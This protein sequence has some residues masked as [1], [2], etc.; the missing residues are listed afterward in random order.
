[1]ARTA[2][3][4]SAGLTG[5]RK[6]PTFQRDYFD[7]GTGGKTMAPSIGP[8]LVPASRASCT[9]E[10]RAFVRYPASGQSACGLSGGNE[11]YRG[12]WAQLLNISHGGVGLLLSRELENGTPLSILAKSE[13]LNMLYELQARVVNA[14]LQDDGQWLIGCEFF[15]PLREEQLQGLLA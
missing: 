7:Q 5:G 9:V 12:R 2:F 4:A 11:S 8:T 6:K 10:R 1:M 13:A 15:I 3:R 14:S